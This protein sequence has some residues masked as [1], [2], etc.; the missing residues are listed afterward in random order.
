MKLLA[1]GSWWTLNKTMTLYLGSLEAS[2][3]LTMLCDMHD[4][5]PEEEMV[6][7]RQ[8]D[9]QEATGLS[10]YQISKA[11][12]LLEKKN[13]IYRVRESE[14]LQPKLLYKVFEDKVV[15]ILR[16][17]NLTS[18]GE[19]SGGHNN[20]DISN[21]DSTNNDLV[22]IDKVVVKESK[23]GYTKHNFSK[24]NPLSI[25]NKNKVSEFDDMFEVEAEEVDLN[26]LSDEE[27]VKVSDSEL[28]PELRV[29]KFDQIFG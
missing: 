12:D 28:T 2:L 19:N 25:F 1:Q 14:T 5:H 15:D 11:M 13:L 29:A 3:L 24:V 17:K 18:K 8:K 27:L 10:Y 6:W 21:N 20:K 26:N 7:L 4:M 23:E 9:I 16:S 22:N